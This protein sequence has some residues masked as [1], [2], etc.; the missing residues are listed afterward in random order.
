MA[1]VPPGKQQL[2]V[3]ISYS[4]KDLELANAITDALEQRGMDVLIDRRDLPY[5]EQWQGELAELIRNADAVVWVVSQASCISRWCNWELGEVMRLNKRLVPVAAEDLTSKELP[6]A[7]GKVQL[8][9]YEGTFS[10][11]RHIDTL[12]TVLETDLAWVK[13]HT[14]LS[15]RARQWIAKGRRRD[16]LLGGT[17]LRDAQAWLDARRPTAPPP[18]GEVLELMLASRRFLIRRRYWIAASPFLAA[19]AILTPY[20]TALWA[21]T[22]VLPDTNIAMGDIVNSDGDPGFDDSYLGCRLRCVLNRFSHPCVAFT[23]DKSIDPPRPTPQASTAQG[24]V[25]GR[26]VAVPRRRCF[27]K[28][29][30]DFYWKPSSILSEPTDSEI[31]PTFFEK[32]PAPRQSPYRLHWFRTISG[33]PADA[34]EVIAMVDTISYI[35][36]ASTGRVSMALSGAQCMQTCIDLADKCRGFAF[37]SIASRCELFKSVKGV[38]RDASTTRPVFMPA[39]MM[40][41]DDPNA[42]VD[43][44]T[45]YTDCP[46]KL[47]WMPLPQRSQPLPAP[48]AK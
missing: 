7:I 41:C 44:K 34:N 13:E 43:P 45:G 3:F 26:E 12:R 28:Y 33:E 37:T 24:T 8:L 40:G 36:D 16:L 38:L 42:E 30:A 21:L 19:M 48:A 25:R 46:P 27:P 20:A 9:P 14:R 23:Y 4:R 29:A 15:D 18:S 17:Q 31:M 39:T 2:K 11:E 47:S 6:E 32:P 10:L 22:K 1:A 35:T 5:G